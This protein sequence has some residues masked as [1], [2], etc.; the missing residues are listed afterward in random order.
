MNKYLACATQIQKA[1]EADIPAML[2]IWDDGRRAL[3]A[4][5]VPQ[6]ADGYPS[7]VDAREDIAHGW[8]HLVTVGRQPAAVAA[9]K[10]EPDVDYETIEEGAWIS[11]RPYC[12]VHRIATASAMKR[13]GLA[14]YIMEHAARIARE[15]GLA[16]LRIDTHTQ[17]LAMQRFLESN[18]FVRCGV[19]RL[20]RTGEPRVAFEKIL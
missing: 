16:S 18:G 2:R 1:T 12:A 6:W 15:K 11:D 8:A 14:T 10:P 3:A 13:Q 5:G 7:E 19:I 20:H 9:I 4:A 17:N